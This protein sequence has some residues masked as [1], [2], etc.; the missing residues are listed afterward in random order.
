[1][2]G[3]YDAINEIGVSLCFVLNIMQVPWLVG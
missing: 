3:A 2:S 1:M